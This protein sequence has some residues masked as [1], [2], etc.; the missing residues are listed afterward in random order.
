MS[1]VIKY[2][3]KGVNLVTEEPGDG[4][5]YSFLIVCLEMNY[6]NSVCNVAICPYPDGASLSQTVLLRSSGNLAGWSK[7]LAGRSLE[8]Q[9]LHVRTHF[10]W[11]F[12][13]ENAWTAASAVRCAAA[14]VPLGPLADDDDE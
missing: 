13:G 9:A 14:V 1:M 7:E 11:R 6:P 12:K 4:T 3:G 8:A 2:L 5:R 10:G